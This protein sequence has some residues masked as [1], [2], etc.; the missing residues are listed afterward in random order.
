M[1]TTNKLQFNHI[2]NGKFAKN[3]IFKYFINISNFIISQQKI[4]S[5]IKILMSKIC[6]SYFTK[7][8]IY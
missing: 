5:L 1:T 7:W 2:Y 8:V 6:Y 3:H 4:N